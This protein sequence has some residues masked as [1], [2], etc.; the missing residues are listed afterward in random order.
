MRAPTFLKVIGAPDSHGTLLKA[1]SNREPCRILDA[2]AG[3]GSL[4][5]QLVKMGHDVHCADIDPAHFQLPDVPLTQVDM[6]RS[7]AGIDNNYF[8]AA[9]CVNGIHRLF[10]LDSCFHE[11]AR[12]LKPGGTLYV[13]VNNYANIDRRLRF[14]LY[15]SLDNAVN[16]GL[17]NQSTDAPEANV[18]V[19][20]QLPQVINR[21]TTA[22][23]EV[24]SIKPA[25]IRMSHR[26]LTP[27]TWILRIASW[28]LPKKSRKRNHLK[29]TNCSGVFPGGCYMLIEARLTATAMNPSRQAA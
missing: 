5:S 7:L 6:N 12:V 13:N 25:S 9:V 27:L 3:T 8:D 22:G 11:F 4:A 17:C 1:I 15:G 29:W 20:L 14:L 10:S 2:P 21:L 26:V 23:F 19:A 24:Q 16:A 18:R 28:L